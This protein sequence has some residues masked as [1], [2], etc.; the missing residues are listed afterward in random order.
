[1]GHPAHGTYGGGRVAS[2]GLRTWGALGAAAMVALFVSVGPALAGRPVAVHYASP[3]ALRGLHVLSRIDALR[4]A[5]VETDDVAA[6]RRR[7]GVLSVRR[8]VSRLR[9][10]EPGL[11]SQEGGAPLEWQFAATRA[12]LVPDWVERAASSVTIAVVD[13]GADLAAPD[14]AAKAPLT[15]NAATGGDTVDDADGHGTFVASIAAGAPANGDGI[16][17]FG[18]D[19]RLMVVQA[20]RGGTT[21]TDVDEAAAIVWAVDHGARIVNLSI[22]GPQTSAVERQ[23]VSYAIAKGVLLVAAA[24]NYGQAGNRLSY[25]AALIGDAGLVVGASTAAGERAPFSTAARYVSIAA[26]GVRVLGALSPTAPT[27]VFPRATVRGATGVYGFGTGTS[28]AAPQ[29]AGA[30][31]LV[32]GVDTNRSAAEVIRILE[33]TATGDGTRTAQLGWGVLDVAS[34]VARAT[35]VPIPQAAVRAQTAALHTRHRVVT[36]LIVPAAPSRRLTPQALR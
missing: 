9:L 1:M 12:H 35:G 25:P 32:W 36:R 26:P 29:V 33:R 3:S 14:L 28:Y 18:G 31:A 11:E 22:G 6:L 8:V 15:H 24:G 5:K 2:Q 7:P 17:G 20:N 10:G 19:A 4:V 16:A 30:A 34:A 27:S 13:T 21:F 23:A